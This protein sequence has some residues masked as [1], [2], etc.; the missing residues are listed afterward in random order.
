MTS[1]VKHAPRVLLTA[2]AVTSALLISF[3]AFAARPHETRADHPTMPTYSRQRIPAQHH[4]SDPYFGLWVQGYPQ[5][6]RS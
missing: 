2:T 6:T 4:N 1:L 3:P 5:P